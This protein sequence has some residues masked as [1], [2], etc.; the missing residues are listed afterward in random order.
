M[1]LAD[2]SPQAIRRLRNRDQMNVIG[3]EAIRPNGNSTFLAP[4]GHQLHISRIVFLAEKGL[5]P[6]ISTLGHVM[7][8]PRHDQ[9]CQPSHAEEPIESFLNSQYR[10]VSPE[11]EVFDD[12]RVVI[13][14]GSGG[15]VVG[16]HPCCV[17][18]RFPPS[19][20]PVRWKPPLVS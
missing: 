16:G 10:F 17:S 9:S 1:S 15:Q 3:H 8:Q 13:L 11:S 18:S 7:W 14:S 4:I 5:L 19:F 12:L 20:L 6:T 2:R